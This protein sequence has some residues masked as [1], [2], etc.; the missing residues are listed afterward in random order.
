MSP[1]Q[2]D[3][4]DACYHHPVH[5]LCHDPDNHWCKGG[6]DEGGEG[7]DFEDFRYDQPNEDHYQPHLPVECEVYA[8]CGGDAFAAFETEENGVEVAD[9]GGE[10]D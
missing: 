7:G 10:A 8:K 3:G 1:R 2:H 4:D 6:G 5:V 9:E